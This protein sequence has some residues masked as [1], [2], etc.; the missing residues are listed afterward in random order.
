MSQNEKKI[1]EAILAS[2]GLEHLQPTR[3]ARSG[4]NN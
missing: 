2:V 3:D 4:R 1:I